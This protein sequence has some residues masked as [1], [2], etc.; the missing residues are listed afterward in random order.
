M[1]CANKSVTTTEVKKCKKKVQQLLSSNNNLHQHE[2]MYIRTS[3]FGHFH[4]LVQEHKLINMFWFENTSFGCD[5]I[6]CRGEHSLCWHTCAWDAQ[7]SLCQPREERKC[8]LM[9]L[10]PFQGIL[11]ERYRWGST[12][13][14]HFLLCNDIH[15]LTLYCR[16]NWISESSSQQTHKQWWWPSFGMRR[17]LWMGTLPC[18]LN[19]LLHRLL[20]YVSFQ[21]IWTK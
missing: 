5:Y 3:A 19:F 7:I 15:R 9:A 8:A 20:S 12:V 4:V 11:R 18:L 17:A 1:I 2:K 21:T 10:P 16:L 14:V 13:N 6:T